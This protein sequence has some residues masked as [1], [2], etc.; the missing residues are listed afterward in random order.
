[1]SSFIIT[2][3]RRLNGSITAQG[4]KNS[5]LPILSAAYLAAGKSVI[6]NCPRISDTETAVGILKMLGCEVRR[7]GN[8]IYTDSTACGAYEI[9][10]G[11]MC[12]MR[13]SV[14]FLGSVLGRMKKARIFS[15][16][17]CRIGA[18]PVDMHIL[19][20]EKLGAEVTRSDGVLDFCVKENLRGCVIRLPYPSVGATENTLLA[21]AT[22]EGTTVLENAAREPEITDLCAFL[23]RCGADIRGAGESTVV[24]NGVKK[25][26]GAEHTVISDRIATATY[27]AAAAVTN[28]DISVK[29]TDPVHLAALLPHFE[30]TGC[31]LSIRCREIRLRAPKR[32][33]SPGKIVTGPYPAFAT[34]AQAPFTVLA[35]LADG[36]TEITE[37]IFENRFGH[38]SG[39][40]KMGADITLDENSAYITGK[41]SLNGAHVSATDLRCGAALVAA[42]LAA[43]GITRVDGLCY[44]DRGYESFETNLC[45]L[46]ADIKRSRQ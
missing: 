13:S 11:L 36:K 1:M 9:P 16:G 15:P 33:R 17:G 4:S 23:N 20:A 27:L 45:S 41:K 18:R 2:G 7:D 10:E 28:G 43:D 14:L 26:H 12:E 29:N 21:A 3:G 34:D 30:K 5:A 37:K 31:E 6:H 46:N 38:V 25:L 22:A 44:I 40:L 32:L 39:L 8:T 42:G 19:A 35:A 24:I